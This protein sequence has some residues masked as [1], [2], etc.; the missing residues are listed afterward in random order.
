MKNVI[1][2]IFTALL[3]ATNVFGQ[4]DDPILRIFDKYDEKEGVVSITITPALL[5]IMKNGKTKDKKT[6]E[7][8]SKISGL[9][10]FTFDSNTVKNEA[11]RETLLSELRQVVQKGYEPIMKVKSSTERMELY[12][13]TVSENK[14]KQETNA[15]LVISSNDSSVVVM[16]L[17]GIIDESLIDAV[18]K[19]KISVTGN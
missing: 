13:G 3:S 8:I 10:I 17:S 5:G 1:L 11:F 2:L 12:I 16:H 6:Q 15:L 7:L 19:G 18:M 4:K 14:E 9:R